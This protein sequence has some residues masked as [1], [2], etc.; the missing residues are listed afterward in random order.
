MKKRKDGFSFRDF[1]AKEAAIVTGSAIIAAGT[2]AAVDGEIQMKEGKTIQEKSSEVAP[3]ANA[4]QQQISATS[5]IIAGKTEKGFGL[6]MAGIGTALAGG[7][8]IGRK[9][10]KDDEPKGRSR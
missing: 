1:S 7:A 10:E 8:A 4:D 9:N 3:A 2:V 6:L 5:K